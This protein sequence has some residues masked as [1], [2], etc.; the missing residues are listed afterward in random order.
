MNKTNE[1][2]GLLT[3]LTGICYKLDSRSEKKTRRSQEKVLLGRFEIN[4]K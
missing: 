2:I 1:K 4:Q 3:S